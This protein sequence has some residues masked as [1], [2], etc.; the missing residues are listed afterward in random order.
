MSSTNNVMRN[1]FGYYEVDGLGT[2]HEKVR[3]Y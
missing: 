2:I 3:S 1:K